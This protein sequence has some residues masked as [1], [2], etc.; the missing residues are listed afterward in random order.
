MQLAACSIQADCGGRL[1]SATTSTS[2]GAGIHAHRP[3]RRLAVLMADINWA[4][5]KPT[6]SDDGP[7]V[8]LDDEIEPCCRLRRPGGSISTVPAPLC[9]RLPQASRV[10]SKEWPRPGV[11]FSSF[12][13]RFTA[14]PDHRYSSRVASPTHREGI[15]RTGTLR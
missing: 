10:V 14:S 13:A 6:V 9:S 4:K 8:Q 15:A 2:A 12:A 11:C 1:T 7:P 5:L 3:H